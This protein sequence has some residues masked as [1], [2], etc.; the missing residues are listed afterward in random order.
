MR[1]SCGAVVLS[2][3]LLAVAA[4]NPRHGNQ[5][6]DHRQSD[7]ESGVAG[8]CLLRELPAPCSDFY[9]A[10]NVSYHNVATLGIMPREALQ[11]TAADMTVLQSSTA[12]EYFGGEGVVPIQG[13]VS[14]LQQMDAVRAHAADYLGCQL[15][16]TALF[17]STTTALNAVAN[18]LVEG[19]FL[20]PGD[21]V[22]TTDQEHAGG[23]A[24]WAHYNASGAVHLDVIP[25][26]LPDARTVD[27]V[28]ADF[29]AHMQPNTKV[30]AHTRH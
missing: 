25:L 12:N 20:R 3:A 13:G 11:A 8:P 2:A 24:G 26:P 21:R 27:E 29:R 16:E 28:V 30:P 18:G 15:G 22:L 6:R 4:C 5:L 9:V 1:A 19:G 23:I 7:D 14:F 17:P 10:C